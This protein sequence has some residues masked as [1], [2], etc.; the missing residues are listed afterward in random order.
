[1]PISRHPGSR[2]D[3]LPSLPVRSTRDSSFRS[4]RLPTVSPADHRFELDPRSLDP[5]A[6]FGAR[7]PSL[8]EARRR[9]STSAT[10]LRRA[11]NQTTTLVPR[12]DGDHDPL[13]F[14]TD[15][16]ASLARP[17]TGGEPRSVHSPQPQCWF[18]SSCPEFSQPWCRFERPTSEACAAE[19]SE[20]WRARVEGPSEG[21]VSSSPA[22]ISRACVGCVRFVTAHAD[23]VPLLGALRTSAVVGALPKV[24]E[25]LP[26]NGPNQGLR[27]NSA[28][29]R[30]PPSRRPGCL[31]PPRHVKDCLGKH[32]GRIAPSGLHAGSLAHA[33]RTFSPLLGNVFVDGHCEVT[34]QSPA[35]PRRFEST[36]AFVT[37]CPR[38][39]LTTQACHR[40]R[41]TRPST[42]TDCLAR[43]DAGRSA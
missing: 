8:F 7:L 15:H 14:L 35:G 25:P 36:D 6:L 23:C 2:A 38:L 37:R 40:A 17:V 10:A 4:K 22:T 18:L 5:A 41:P 29:R 32:R 19:H 34:V 20:D 24:E 42:R 27:S 12:R 21:R 26:T 13:P 28:P 30:A 43:T 1:M 31:S 33:A 9:L 3:P 11:G 39:E 16:A